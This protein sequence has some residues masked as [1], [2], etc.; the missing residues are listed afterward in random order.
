MGFLYS[1][2]YE[3]INT[4][5]AGGER[6][7]YNITSEILKQRDLMPIV[8]IK[9]KVLTEDFNFT[10]ECAEGMAELAYHHQ[11]GS[12]L[13]PLSLIDMYSTNDKSMDDEMLLR[14]RAAQLGDN[15]PQGVD[16]DEAIQMICQTLMK[17]GFDRISAS[18]SVTEYMAMEERLAAI[19]EPAD[20]VH[21]HCL[22]MRT[23]GKNKNIRFFLTSSLFGGN[24]S[25]LLWPM[26]AM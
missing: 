15:F 14:M 2:G 11:T 8:S 17:E 24:L 3:E 22:L 7:V 26:N 25:V 13:H 18:C 23:G 1:E 9:P 20:V 16:I 19:F 10:V 4:K 12:Q 21:Y 5:I 6:D